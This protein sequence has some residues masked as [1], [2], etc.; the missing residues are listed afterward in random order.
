M[1]H[2]RHVGVSCMTE[3]T[4]MFGNIFVLSDY[5]GNITLKC[6]ILLAK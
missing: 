6:H 3:P 5:R 4:E 1:N 2:Y